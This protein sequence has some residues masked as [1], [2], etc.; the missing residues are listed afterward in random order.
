MNELGMDCLRWMQMN[1]TPGG[2]DFFLYVTQFGEG[3][4]LM[5]ILGVLFWVWGA[6]VAYRAGLALMTGDLVSSVVKNACCIPRPWVRDPNVLPVGAAQWGAFGYS[7]PS[8]H[9][10]SSA[11]LWG[12]IAAA[13]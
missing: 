12:G 3:F 4:W 6:R 5:A 7:F 9:A 8:G 1:R 2:E 11:L 13:E 10:S